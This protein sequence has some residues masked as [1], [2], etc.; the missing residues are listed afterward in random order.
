MAFS[1]EEILLII[2]FIGAVFAF[3]TNKLIALT[4][5]LVTLH[6]KHDALESSRFSMEDRISKME[7]KLTELDKNV[8]IMTVQLTS[9]EKGI[10]KLDKVTS[11]IFELLEK[12]A[13]KVAV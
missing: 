13:D 8:G 7:T 1:V 5:D 4:K 10:D 9:I 3:I 2:G 12:K 6:D 11:K